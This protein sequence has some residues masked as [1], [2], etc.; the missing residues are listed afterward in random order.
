MRPLG[1]VARTSQSRLQLRPKR[2]DGFEAT[3]MSPLQPTTEAA[4]CSLPWDQINGAAVNL[5]K[6]QGDLLFPCFFGAFV[7]FVVQAVDE[8]VDQRS[9]RVGR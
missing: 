3:R 8:G 9:T 5:T 1:F 7:N 6:T 4:T 2:Q